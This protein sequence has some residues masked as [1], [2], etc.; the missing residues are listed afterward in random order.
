M[1]MKTTFG[2][3]KDVRLWT[4]H[5]SDDEISANRF[6][7]AKPSDDL[8]INLKLMDGNLE[9]IRNVAN[10]TTMLGSPVERTNVTFVQQDNENVVCPAETFFDERDQ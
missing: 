2:S 8:I 10:Q 4:S 9:E 6:V 7:Q 3:F 5:R 1:K